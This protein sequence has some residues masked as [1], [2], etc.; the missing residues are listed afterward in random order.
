MRGVITHERSGV[1]R[2]AFRALGLDF[3]SCDLAPAEDG[4][5][6]HLQ[7]DAREVLRE[8][9]DFA[10]IHPECR[11]LSVSGMHWNGR[12]PGRAEKTALALAHA[13]D[14]WELVRKLPRGYMENPVSI[15]STRIGKPDQIIQ[16]YQFGEDASKATC[17]WLHNLPRLSI[18]P[19]DQW[20][21]PR[22]VCPSCE[23]VMAD[24]DAQAWRDRAGII[25]CPKCEHLPR[26]LP[27]W[28]NQ[29]DSGQNR[30]GPSEKRS[31]D[32]ARTYPR[33]AA[34]MAQQ[35]GGLDACA[36]DS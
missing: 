12:V 3:Y 16:P 23:R 9:W 17:L 19:P 26:Q 35:W 21:P 1:I 2:E 24:A 5:P 6:F 30:L 4:S 13:R 18:S 25:R 11:Y 33:I 7:A 22:W 14:C 15:L 36:R 8:P 20:A 34:A 29:T 10:G 31:M 28:S 32:R 27:R